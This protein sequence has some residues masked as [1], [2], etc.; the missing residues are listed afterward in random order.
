MQAAAPQFGFVPDAKVHHLACSDHR[1]TE[2]EVV[3]DLDHFAATHR[4]TVEDVCPGVGGGFKTSE[5][6]IQHNDTKKPTRSAAVMAYTTAS[7][8]ST[9]T[10][11]FFI[12][13][14]YR[15]LVQRTPCA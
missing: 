13:H 15:W 5:M 4:A 8:T 14:W 3:A 2:H 12:W 9:K 7:A 10:N 11:R 1:D 6:S